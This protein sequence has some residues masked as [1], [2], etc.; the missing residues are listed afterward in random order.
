M[1]WF[2]FADFQQYF[3][4]TLAPRW[5]YNWDQSW[6]IWWKNKQTGSRMKKALMKRTSSGCDCRPIVGVS[7]ALAAVGDNDRGAFVSGSLLCRYAEVRGH[8]VM[9]GA[10]AGGGAIAPEALRVIEVLQSISCQRVGCMLVQIGPRVG[11][12]GVEGRGQGGRSWAGARATQ[13]VM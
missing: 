10:S 9:G 12:G 13:R 11:V 1:H 8:I 2:S 5:N 6:S 7:W 3:S 4:G